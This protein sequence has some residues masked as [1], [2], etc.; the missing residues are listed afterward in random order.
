MTNL[1]AP[2]LIGLPMAIPLDFDDRNPY[3]GAR[4]GGPTRADCLLELSRRNASYDSAAAR[5]KERESS[6]M[7]IFEP[8]AVNNCTAEAAA[9][10][11]S[12]KAQE[13]ACNLL[14]VDVCSG[15]G[16][17][18]AA[19]GN[20]TCEGAYY[21][22]TCG[23]ALRCAFWN[24]SA[25]DGAGCIEVGKDEQGSLQCECTHLTL[26]EALYEVDWSDEDVYKT[27]AFPL[28]S[29]PFSRWE[30]LWSGLANMHPTVYYIMIG[31]LTLLTLLLLWARQRDRASEYMAYMPGWYKAVR[32]VERAARYSPRCWVRVLAW[33]LLFLLWFV[34]NH[35]WIVVF[36]VR[37][38]DQ[39]KHAHLVMMLYNIILAELCFFVIFFGYEQSAGQAAIACILDEGI[40]WIL[41]G[42]FAMLFRWAMAEP[43]VDALELQDEEGWHLVFRQSAPFA[44]PHGRADLCALDAYP[45]APTLTLV[46]TS[47]LTHSS[48][49]TLTLTLHPWTRCE[50]DY[51][52][53]NFSKLSR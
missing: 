33:P 51:L 15:K 45:P 22:A 9:L 40:K 30:A 34:T 52:S 20:C 53:D 26:F 47:T 32:S 44:W 37:P 17:C 4:C 25:F 23:L 42:L 18:N 39:F 38:S 35:P 14:Q 21:G 41:L 50:F 31:L 3:T 24:G 7:S 49:P 28:V 8:D 43:E 27:I 36:L 1:T 10:R 48:A 13:D 19:T 16:S 2:V 5:C 12:F 29:L 6:F 46:L 11:R